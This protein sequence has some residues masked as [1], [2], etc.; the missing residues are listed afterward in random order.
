VFSN[1]SPS[2]NTYENGLITPADYD[3]GIPFECDVNGDE[4]IGLEEVI[5]ALRILSGI[6][7]K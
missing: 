4:R 2:E 7:T 6:A 5:N 1:A 3:V